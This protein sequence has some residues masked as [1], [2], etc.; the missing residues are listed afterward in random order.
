MSTGLEPLRIV[1][2]INSSAAFGR[3]RRIGAVVVERLS[4]AGHEVIPLSGSGYDEQRAITL[5]SLDPV[6]DALVVVGGDGMV[7]LGTGLVARRGIPLGIVPTGT[8]NDLAR[9]LGIPVGDTDA[10]IDHLL[11]RLGS[12]PRVIDAGLITLT[13]GT[14][15]WF[16]GVLS[17]GIDAMVNERANRMRR[18]SGKSRYTI[19]LLRELATLRPLRYALALDGQREERPA[20]LVAIANNS[21]F[22][23]GMRVAPDA[24]LDD[25]MFDVVVLDPVH[26]RA[27][28][29]IFPRVFAGTHIADRRVSVRRARSVMIDCPDVIAYAD[30]ERIGAMPLTCDVVPGALAVLA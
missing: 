3:G 19:A 23:G 20:M 15:R 26:R 9:G 14:T 12:P 22:G 5:A 7:N 24:L 27:L 21:S 6:P 18:P 30:G 28:V 8:G 13:D 2:A 16:A 11:A 29:A 10:A 4:T 17:G 1:V 25:G